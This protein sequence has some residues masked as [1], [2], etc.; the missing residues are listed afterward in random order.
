M[1]FGVREDAFRVMTVSSAAKIGDIERA[2]MLS[3]QKMAETKR[4]RKAQKWEN[5]QNE[6]IFTLKTPSLY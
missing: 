1:N 2:N 5:G 4:R 3:N 6:G